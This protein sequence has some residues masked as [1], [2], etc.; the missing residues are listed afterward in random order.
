MVGMQI[1]I[2]V[3]ILQVYG[4]SFPDTRSEWRDEYNGT[5]SPSAGALHKLHIPETFNTSHPYLH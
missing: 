5:R 4:S 1:F 2:Q 3:H